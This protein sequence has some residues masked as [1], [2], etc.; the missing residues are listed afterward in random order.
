[1]AGF[2]EHGNVLEPEGKRILGRPWRR[3]ENSIKMNLGK[4]SYRVKIGLF[5]LR[6]GTG[7]G[8]L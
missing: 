8:L 4:Q 5:W 3:W 2:C 1:V 7:G 6:I